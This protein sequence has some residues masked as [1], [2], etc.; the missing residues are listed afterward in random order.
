MQDFDDLTRALTD[1]SAELD[2]AEVHGL[3]S[4]LACIPG[5]S[6]IAVLLGEVFGPAVSEPSVAPCRAVLGEVW[7]AT[8][9]ALADTDFEFEPLLPDDETSLADRTRALGEW[10]AGYL[11]GLGLG[12]VRMFEQDFSPE[13]GEFMRDLQEMSRIEP[14]PDVDDETES[15][16]VE[17]VEYVRVGVMLLGEELEAAGRRAPVGVLH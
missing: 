9:R 4:A 2:A 8:H 11:A 3:L 17:L 6:R 15:A 7:D 14:D 16:Y 1:A 5:D 12:G 13:A 10:C